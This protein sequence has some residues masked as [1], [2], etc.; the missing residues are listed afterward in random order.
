MILKCNNFFQLKEFC[1]D[2]IQK[3]YGEAT[4]EKRPCVWLQNSGFV[5][6]DADGKTHGF[7]LYLFDTF[8]A[9][10]VQVA[11]SFTTFLC[12]HDKRHKVLQHIE[13]YN[14]TI[15]ERFFFRVLVPSTSSFV[16]TWY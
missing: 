1:A 14:V 8:L 15:S 9:L 2:V 10:L 6:L 13:F 3:R 11:R 4:T 5:L 7:G 16:N 12:V